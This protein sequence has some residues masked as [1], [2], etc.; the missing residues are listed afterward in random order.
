MTASEFSKSLRLRVLFSENQ[1]SVGAALEM[2]HICG[3]IGFAAIDEL[4]AEIFWLKAS[5]LVAIY[6][7]INA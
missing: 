4:V 6:G 5:T 3:I 1:P 7:G 2:R